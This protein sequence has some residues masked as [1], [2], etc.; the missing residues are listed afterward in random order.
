MTT[1]AD[2]RRF[3]RQTSAALCAGAG[4]ALM[5]GLGLIG[6]ALAST[7][8]GLPGYKALV[9]VYLAGGNDS[10]N[11]LVPRDSINPGSRYSTYRDS[12]GGVYNAN[13][14]PFGLALDF[15]AL[16]DI[17]TPPGQATAFGLH[18]QAAD[19]VVTRNGQNYNHPGLATLFAQQR[20]AFVA[21]VGPLVQPTSLTQFNAGAPIPPQLYSHSDQELQW[22]LG[23]TS[24][25]VQHG[26][27]GRAMDLIDPGGLPILSPCISVAGNTRYQVGSS[28]FP[29]QMSPSTGVTQLT[30]FTGG[31]NFGDQRRA[32]LDE[33][34]AQSS[35]HLL[36]QEYRAVL[37]RSRQLA[38]LL[39][40]ALNSSAGRITTPYDYV[41]GTP[42]NPGANSYPNA[43]VRVLGNDYSNQLLDQLRM[44]ARMIKVSRDP[45]A[46]VDQSRQIYYVRLDGFDTHGD[47]MDLHPL[48]LGRLT[49]A[50]GWF[51]QAM[52]EINAQN[53]VTLFTMSD[54]G[55]TLSSNGDGT[56]HAW[57]GVQF[58]VG[59][60]VS[61]GQ[62]YGRYPRL[63][64][65]AN[66]DAEQDW[67]F[68][69]GQY[70]PSSA[71]DQMAA[72]LARWLGV[73]AGDLATVF[74]NLGNFSGP[75]GFLPA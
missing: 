58:A 60:A 14:N 17:G 8:G 22:N 43:N 65:N 6:Q 20:L 42:P 13:T 19:Y 46:G 69:R 11:L 26:W 50:I 57:G 28:V 66:N 74:P 64:A 1:H 68:G 5:P 59:G 24:A 62:I 9:C 61:G 7:R 41:G 10:F 30:N 3:L 29:Y 53:D 33:L 15:N 48:L 39:Q 71:S 31:F 72:T 32:A 49:Q 45:L 27:G 36:T 25:S 70:I 37:S 73:G 56:D 2:R 18:P 35:P 47:Q 55:R 34:L 40:A 51:W 54:F 23:T 67:S 21:N 12:R 75:L 63:V 16:L 52:G 38:S 4:A 44:V